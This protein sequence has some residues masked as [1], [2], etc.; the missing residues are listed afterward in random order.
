[1]GVAW[2]RHGMCKL[3]FRRALPLNKQPAKI[4]NAFEFVIDIYN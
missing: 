1:M 3:A 4:F 2:A